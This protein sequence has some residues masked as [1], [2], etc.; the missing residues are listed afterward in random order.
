MRTSE[1]ANIVLSACRSISLSTSDVLARLRTLRC[2]ECM[3]TIPWWSRRVWLDDERCSHLQCFQGQLFLKA[4]VAD[5]IR[6]SQLIAREAPLDPR[7]SRPGDSHSAENN[8][9]NPGPSATAAEPIELLEA[10][11]EQTEEVP[12]PHVVENQPGGNSCPRKLGL[13]VW[14]FI[15]RFAPN[16]PPP[17][18]RLC[19]LCGGVEFGETSVFCSKC[20]TS[21]RPSS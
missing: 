9:R 6:R 14:H 16:R 12:K 20:G 18:A 8:L 17:P 7:G 5:E 19:M 21:L 2:D 1:G 10:V 15:G 11:P 4:F 13:S 3:R